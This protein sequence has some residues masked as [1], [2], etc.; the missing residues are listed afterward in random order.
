M[1]CC[2]P[3]LQANG[4]STNLGPGYATPLDAFLNGPREKIVYTSAVYTGTGVN[5]PDFLATVDVDPESPTYS[6]II[7]QLPMPFVGDELHHSGWN[8]CSSCHGDA[9]KQR[10][11]LVLASLQSGNIYAVDVGKDPRAP[12]LHKTV[13]GEEIKEKLGLTFPHS[14][15]CLANGQLMISAMGDREGNASGAGFVLLNSDFS[16]AGRWEAGDQRPEFSYDFWYQPRHNVLVSSAWGAPR[17]FRNG[18]D[19]A[20]VAGGHYGRQL[21]IWDWAAHTLQQTIDLGVGTLPLEVRFL[22]NPDR[23]EGFVAGALSSTLFRFFKK[24]DGSWA[25]EVAHQWEPVEV[26]GWALPAMPALLTDHVISLDDKYLYTS[27]W[28]HGDLRQWDISDTQNVRLAGRLFVGGSLRKGGPVTP[29]SEFPQ[30]AVA[31]VK[32]VELQ[33]G[34]Q[35]V[36]LSLDGRRLYVTNSLFSPWDK[37]FY[38]DIVQKGSQLFLVDVDVER[39]GLSLNPNFIVDFGALPEGPALAHETRYPGGDCTSDIWV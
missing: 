7:H 10:R 39:G 21:Y 30:P 2:E 34:P 1:S 14:I 8:A 9:S 36:Q 13:K 26:E 20:D 23:A 32:G 12:V 11:Y 6:T 4:H 17:V 35:M 19:P 31:K 15:H 16:V 37:Q 33:G 24:D 25:T 22:H 18:F 38:P 5:R 29:K 3:G 28:L 27:S